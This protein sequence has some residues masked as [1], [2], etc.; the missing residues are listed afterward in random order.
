MSRNG[1]TSVGSVGAPKFFPSTKATLSEVRKFST[2][3]EILR[4]HGRCPL[5]IYVYPES[6]SLARPAGIDDDPVSALER[7]SVDLDGAAQ[8]SSVDPVGATQ[9]FFVIWAIVA[10]AIFCCMA[11]LAPQEIFRRP[12]RRRKGLEKIPTIR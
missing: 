8:G 9:K 3:H 6:L 5:K 2:T 4:W 10:Q 1:N 11:W 7:S 12:S